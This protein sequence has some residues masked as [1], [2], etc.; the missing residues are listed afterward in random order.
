MKTFFFLRLTGFSLVRN[1][2][3][4][5]LKL[6]LLIG[7][8]LFSISKRQFLCHTL[9]HLVYLQEFSVRHYI[10]LPVKRGADDMFYLVQPSD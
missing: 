1:F 5:L 2:R 6:R 7:N 8:F 4:H 10:C 3:I 9:K